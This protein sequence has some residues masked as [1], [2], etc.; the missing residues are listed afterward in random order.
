V[1]FNKIS[2]KAR[3][4]IP[5]QAIWAKL[6]GSL[7]EETDQ[8]RLT[9]LSNAGVALVVWLQD[10]SACAELTQLLHDIG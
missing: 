9:V 10:A 8:E 3:L 7:N 5:F 2:V 1:E 6:I 4:H